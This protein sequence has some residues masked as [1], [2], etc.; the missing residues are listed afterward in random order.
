MENF[1]RRHIGMPISRLRD[2]TGLPEE[3]IRTLL[4]EAAAPASQDA[5]P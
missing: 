3:R 2:L 1:V 5:P 4:K